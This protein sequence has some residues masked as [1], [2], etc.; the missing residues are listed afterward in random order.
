ME[1][2][3]NEHRPFSYHSWHRVGHRVVEVE[4][5]TG[6]PAVQGRAALTKNLPAPLTLSTLLQRGG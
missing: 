6:H 3:G 2:L 1:T 4:G 5:A